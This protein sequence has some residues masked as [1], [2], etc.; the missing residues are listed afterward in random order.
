MDKELKNRVIHN[1]IISYHRLDSILVDSLCEIIRE[2]EKELVDLRLYK[3][4]M[5]NSDI[6]GDDN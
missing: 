4:K 5:E 3:E 6:Q 1:D 2:M